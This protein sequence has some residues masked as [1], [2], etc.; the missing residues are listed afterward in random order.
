MAFASD[1]A[2]GMSMPQ[3]LPLEVPLELP[4]VLPLDDYFWGC[5]WMDI[6]FGIA[7]GNVIAPRVAL[8]PFGVAHSV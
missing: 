8:R 7:H 6:A 3:G 2:L 4:C 1:I 5:P